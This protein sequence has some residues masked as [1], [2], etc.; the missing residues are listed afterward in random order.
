MTES[1]RPDDAAADETVSCVLDGEAT[2]EQVALVAG[3]PELSERLAEFT[4]L[5]ELMGDPL[6]IPAEE[7]DRARV[8]VVEKAVAERA[9]EHQHT[10]ARQTE[11]GQATRSTQSGGV[12]ELA[13]AR[14][15]RSRRPGAA[16]VASMAAALLVAA[17]IGY[18]I[19]ELSDDGDGLELTALDAADDDEERATSAGLDDPA[20]DVADMADRAE[21]A[22]FSD[23]ADDVADTADS[24][25]PDDAS[26][27]SASAIDGSEDTAAST[28]QAAEQAL[29]LD[30]DPLP[31]FIEP[32][33]DLAALAAA[34]SERIARYDA[35]GGSGRLQ[36]RCEALLV[37]QAFA[38]GAEAVDVSHV[39]VAGESFV[40]AVGRR[41]DPPSVEVLAAPEPAC[42]PVS[43]LVLGDG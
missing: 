29:G 7:I 20:E 36:P 11:A 18:G 38:A 41:Y 39:L 14:R 25:R 22:D 19:A 24:A 12:V 17:G 33:P 2:A 6:P 13:G 5:A 10:G 43:D 4:A 35:A 42:E 16:R 9:A 15:R 30:F 1:L 8:G 37:D 27:D 40:V 23:A 34:L 31:D 26:D 3:S 32:V 28:A 21:S